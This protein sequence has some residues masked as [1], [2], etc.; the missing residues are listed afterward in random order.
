MS[1]VFLFLLE[2]FGENGSQSYLVFQSFSKY[3]SYF[4]NRGGKISSWAS[5]G[6]SKERIK[7]PRT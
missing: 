6:T 5:K 2:Y 1:I 3:I 4:R 7:Y